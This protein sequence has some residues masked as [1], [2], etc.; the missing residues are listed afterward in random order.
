[1]LARTTLSLFAAAVLTVPVLAKKAEPLPVEVG[2]DL[3]YVTAAKLSPDGSRVAYTI[4][5]P[6]KA[7]DKP[8]GRKS[9]LWVTTAK[10]GDPVLFVSADRQ[11]S[12]FGFTPDSKSLSFLRKEDKEGG[13]TQVFRL[14][15]DG[16]EAEAITASK[17]SIAS[18]KWSPDGK[19]LAYTVRDG[20]TEEDKE[21]KKK[22]TDANVVHSKWKFTR[23]KVL[24]LASGETHNVVDADVQ[25]WSY[26]WSPDS[27][28]F[29]IKISETTLTDHQYM[30]TRIAGV[31]AAGGKPETLFQTEGKLGTPVFTRDGKWIVWNGGVDI[32]DPS[33]SSVFVGPAAGGEQRNLTGDFEGTTESVMSLANGDLVTVTV[34]RQKTVIRSMPADGS[35]ATSKVHYEGP[36]VIRSIDVT[37]DGAFAFTGSAPDHHYEL[38]VG[39]LGGDPERRSFLNPHLKENALGEQSIYRWTARDGLEIEGVL[40]K[41]VGFQKGV[42]YP[43][44]L[45]IHGGPEGVVTNGWNTSYGYWSQFLASRGFVVL[46]PNYRAS[47]GRG[48]AFAKADHRDLGGAEFTDVIDAIDALAA[49]GMVDPE[50]VGIGGGSYGGY[51]SAWAATRHT[52]R[53]AAAMTFA[54]V[55]NWVSMLGTSDIPEENLLVHWNLP[56][57]GNMYQFMERSP[58]M[59]IE[60]SKTPTLIVHGEKDLRVPIGQSW[61][62][63]TIMKVMGKEVEFVTLPREPHG[64]RERAH[65]IGHVNRCIE[66]YEKYLKPAAPEG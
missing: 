48:V 4:S 55:S 53:F 34:E 27:Q 63:Y 11:A 46:M 52:D 44:V 65:Q 7:D 41:P 2:L 59:W 37:A 54:G 24:D 60:Q 22:G 40:V 42:R 61:E 21:N 26:D 23:L 32:H 33:M 3:R 45:N 16:G 9:E 64:I 10:G 18:Y 28:R 31:D 6:R 14:P 47:I 15:L 25:T 1:M 20:E 51:F 29:V 49:E 57:E 35:H 17:E 8:G 50:R 43:L 12:G 19:Q 66:W 62:L 13:K 39:K 30:F 5:I 58:V 38:F 56:A 36:A